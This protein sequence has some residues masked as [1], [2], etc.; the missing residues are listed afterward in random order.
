MGLS[1]CTRRLSR[2]PRGAGDA[3]L[4]GRVNL[5]VFQR[6]LHDG[7]CSRRASTVRR[8]PRVLNIVIGSYRVK[9]AV[10]RQEATAH[11]PGLVKDEV[12]GTRI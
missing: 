6:T 9:L 10:A 4:L 2:V 3:R 11:G 7:N 8:P 12:R 5:Q 1:L